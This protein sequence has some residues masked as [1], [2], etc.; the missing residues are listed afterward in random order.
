MKKSNKAF[1]LIELLV[2]VLIIGILAAIAVPQYQRAVDRAQVSKMMP[3]INAILQAED[4]YYL[5]NG[6][7]ALDLSELDIDVTKNCIW[8]GTKK[9][10]I[11]CPGFVLNNGHV[12]GN[13]TGQLQLLFCPTATDPTQWTN[14]MDCY[15]VQE[16]S[17]VYAYNHPTNYISEEDIGKVSCTSASAR[18]QRLESMFCH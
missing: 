13:A 15:N 18:G 5:S 7:Y 16:L 14:Y 9:H 11:W 6:K 2:V 17:V 10:Q 12:S 4:V 8:G 3:M 1:T